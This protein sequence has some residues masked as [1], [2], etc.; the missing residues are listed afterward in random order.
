MIDI[1]PW[2]RVQKWWDRKVILPCRLY[3]L[4]QGAKLGTSKWINKINSSDCECHCGKMWHGGKSLW[5]VI[6]HLSIRYSGGSSS[7]I[8]LFA[9][10][11]PLSTLLCQ[12]CVPGSRSPYSSYNWVKPMIP[13]VCVGRKREAF[14]KCWWTQT[15]CGP[16]GFGMRPSK[17]CHFLRHQEFIWLGVPDSQIRLSLLQLLVSLFPLV[18]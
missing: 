16:W 7:L 2:T 5:R 13:Q 15:L 6:Q 8:T 17:W 10:P 11:D 9:P 12:H 14:I 1:V 18:H 4:V 3:I